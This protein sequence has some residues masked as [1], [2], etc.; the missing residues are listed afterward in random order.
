[1]EY[2]RCLWCG[3]LFE[4]DEGTYR[5]CDDCIGKIEDVEGIVEKK[6][7]VY[8]NLCKELESL[9]TA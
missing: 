2:K 1:M 9:L 3:K 5:F 8:V 6:T 4:W 7:G